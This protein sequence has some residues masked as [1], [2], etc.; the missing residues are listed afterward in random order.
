MTGYEPSP[1][2]IYKVVLTEALAVKYALGK[3][4]KI[5]SV[6]ANKGI[7]LFNV[8]FGVFAPAV[9][10]VALAPKPKNAVLLPALI[11]RY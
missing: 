4:V 7:Q 11:T 6:P 8:G 9:A 1:G 3:N 5:S 10:V 2:V